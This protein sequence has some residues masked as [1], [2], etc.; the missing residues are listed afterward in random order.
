MRRLAVITLAFLGMAGCSQH[1]AGDCFQHIRDGFIW[2]VTEASWRRT[3]VQGWVR[4]SW[5]IPVE[6]PTRSFLAEEY[7]RIECP[8]YVRP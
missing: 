7:V 6:L 5:G 2:R 3:M 1:K 8:L 4:G